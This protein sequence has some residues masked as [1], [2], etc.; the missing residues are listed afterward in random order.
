MSIAISNIAWES[1][2][3]ERIAR[4][5]PALGATGIELAPTKRWSSPAEASEEEAATYRRWWEGQGLEVVALQSLLYGRDDLRIFGDAHPRAQTAEYLIRM[6]HL[7]ARLGATALVF[8]SPKN[9]QTGPLSQAEIDRIA[10]PF[11]GELGSAAEEA[12]V[13]LCIEPNPPQYA[14][15]WLTHTAAAVEFLDVVGSQGLGLHLDA[16]ALTLNDEAVGSAFDLAAPWLRHF[17]ASEPFLAPL[18]PQVQ[19]RHR[20]YAAALAR[21]GYAGYVSIEM[22]PPQLPGSAQAHVAAALA[23]VVETYAGVGRARDA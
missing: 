4:A 15:D 20:E 16:A 8:G 12:G 19:G 5:L 13:R 2:D 1:A 9:R 18:G 11:F 10:I 22:R 14:C 6:I 17:H 7:G 21:I 23:Y 3:E